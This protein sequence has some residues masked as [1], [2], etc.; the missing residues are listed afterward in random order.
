MTG[1][2]I[3]A[4]KVQHAQESLWQFLSALP[5]SFEAQ[6]FYAILLGGLVGML[7]NYW[8]K[9]LRNEISGSLFGYL[10]VNNMRGTMLSFV[11]AVGTGIAGI[12]AGVFETGGGDFVGWFNV[13]WIAVSNG[14]FWDAAA[15]KGERPVWTPA[16][17]QKRAEIDGKAP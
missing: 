5:G 12:T 8:I 11:S 15:N 2:K 7:L 4:L 16:E 10:F 14:F 13:L 9:W 6:I 3:S 17:R 1:E